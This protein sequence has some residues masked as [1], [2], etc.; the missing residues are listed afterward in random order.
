MPD[1]QTAPV[2]AA[3]QRQAERFIQ[4][5][6]RH[7]AYGFAYPTSAHCTRALIG[8]LR[9]YNRR[10][11]SIPAQSAISQCCLGSMTTANPGLPS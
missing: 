1:E 8:W 11:P 2:H 4:I 3:H 9:W 10:R 6:L 7:C 5:L